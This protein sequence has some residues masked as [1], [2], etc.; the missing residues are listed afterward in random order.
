MGSSKNIQTEQVSNEIL[1]IPNVISFIRL[2]M[3]PC[4]CLALLSDQDFIAAALFATAAATDFVDGQ[5]AR[6]TGKV[7]KLGQILDPTVDRCLMIF[8]VISLMIVGRLPLWIV[9]FVVVRDLYLLI[10]GAYLLKRWNRRVPV[11]YLGKFA[12]TLLF[13]GFAFLI[14]N[15]PIIN[16]LGVCSISWLPGFNA[17]PCCIGI[18]LIYAGLILAAITTV[19]YS[20]CA[21]NLKE[22]AKREELAEGRVD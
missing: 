8:G 7:T 12:T 2:C 6:R 3:V 18:W 9:V 11:I 10:G 5:I 21:W 1:T 17:A 14:L 22:E 15:A 20:I 19:H 16:G 13:V 4:F